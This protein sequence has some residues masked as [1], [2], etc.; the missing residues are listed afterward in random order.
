MRDRLYDIYR[1]DTGAFVARAW[2]RP[3]NGNLIYLPA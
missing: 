3:W 2:T 1:R